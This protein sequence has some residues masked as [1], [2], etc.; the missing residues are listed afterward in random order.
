MYKKVRKQP[1]T[2]QDWLHD[3]LDTMFNNEKNK[4]GRGCKE[5]SIFKEASKREKIRP[6]D[7]IPG[8]VQ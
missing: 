7:K 4:K 8:P 2:C 6:E 3:R 5:A 1:S